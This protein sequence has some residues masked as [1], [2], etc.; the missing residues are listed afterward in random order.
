MTRH[1]LR[2]A[3]AIVTPTVTFSVL[4]HGLS[5]D[6]LANRYGDLARPCIVWMRCFSGLVDQGVNS[7]QFLSVMTS[8]APSTTLIAV[9][10]SIA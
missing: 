5:A 8:T 4:G 1:P 2:A 10:S 7:V 3:L 6:P 9:S